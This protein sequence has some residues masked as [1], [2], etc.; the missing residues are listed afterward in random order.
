MTTSKRITSFVNKTVLIL[1]INR[2]ISY[3]VL[4]R[5]WSALAGPITI[6]LIATRFTKEQQGFYYTILSL[7]ALQIFF[8]LGLMGVISTFVSHEFVRLKWGDFGDV[9]GEEKTRERF[10]EFLGK[11]TKW[12]VIV[13]ILFV[14]IVAPSGF[15]FL[16]NDHRILSNFSWKIPWL[17]TVIGTSL[18]LCATPLLATISGS[19]DVAT[20]NH[21]QMI[22]AL[23][24]TCLS[25]I[26]IES[27][28]GLY[29]LF[30][31]V[32]GNILSSYKYLFA[33]K[34]LLVKKAFY[35]AFLHKSNLSGSEGISWRHEIW[36]LQWKIALSWF[37][38][39]FI[40]QIFTPILFHYH[41]ATVAG[42]M[43][44]TLS[45]SNAL[46]GVCLTWINA[47]N[48]EFCRLIAI[49][50]WYGLDKSFKRIMIQ[51]TGISIAGAFAGWGFI[52][53]LQS[54]FTWGHRFIPASQALFLM[55]SVVCH[56]AIYGFASY[57]RA[58]KQEPLMF[59]SL[60]LALIQGTATYY[61]G[62]HYGT[63]GM[64]LSFFI[65]SLALFLPSVYFIWSKSRKN[66]HLI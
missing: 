65:I 11:T 48:P 5:T 34:P 26:V 13:S 43:G 58:H 45:A 64:T 15:I 60:F 29:A 42:E 46:L 61:F 9:I 21:R 12:Y 23:T 55:I 6:L 33:K 32:F 25:W 36:P 4:S 7:L 62:R 28:G 50:D 16:E 3:G 22:G 56:S 20:V 30:A 18:N 17:I 41:G 8:E 59:I 54:H 57:L 14:A 10:F 63:Q 27:G 1:G 44:L 35:Y 51:C 19:G 39:Y 40:F 66:W 37:S 52:Y 53:Y 2:A 47:N 49:R 38:G 24:G 31:V